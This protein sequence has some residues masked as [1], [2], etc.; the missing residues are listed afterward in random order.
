SWTPIRGSKEEEQ[1]E[2]EEMEE[3]EPAAPNQANGSRIQWRSVASKQAKS[4]NHFKTV[5]S[6]LPACR[7]TR[8]VQQEGHLNLP[9]PERRPRPARR[10]PGPS[11]CVPPT[12]VVACARRGSAPL[13]Q[14][15]A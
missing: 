10:S 4:N 3:E 1:E 6:Y 2:E 5:R 8:C 11:S 7:S 14:V 12:D 13:R 9:A 15:A